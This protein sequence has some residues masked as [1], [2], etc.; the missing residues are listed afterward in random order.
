MLFVYIYFR[1]YKV[2]IDLI[3]F[4]KGTKEGKEGNSGCERSSAS[5]KVKYQVS[6]VSEKEMQS[7]LTASLKFR[8]DK[9]ALKQGKTGSAEV[10]VLVSFGRFRSLGGVRPNQIKQS[11]VCLYSQLI[12][13][14]VSFLAVVCFLA[15]RMNSGSAV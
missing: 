13:A 15:L 1:S 7:G 2:H 6:V 9:M 8:V 4:R 5:V 14:Q 12:S 10:R 3:Q 11:S